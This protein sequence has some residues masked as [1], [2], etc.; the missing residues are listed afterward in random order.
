[1]YIV[2]HGIT[3]LKMKTI[4]E[5]WVFAHNHLLTSPYDRR[6]LIEDVNRGLLISV[7]KKPKG[8]K[9]S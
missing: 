6:V 9:V 5:C 4:D 8:V 2:K 7:S 1:M 3:E